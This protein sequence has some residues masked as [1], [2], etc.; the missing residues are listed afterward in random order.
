[1]QR[2]GFKVAGESREKRLISV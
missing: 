1:M 2:Q